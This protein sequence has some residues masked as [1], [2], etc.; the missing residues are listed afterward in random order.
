MV[1]QTFQSLGRGKGFSVVSRESGM[2]DSRLVEALKP[3]LLSLMAALVSHGHAS[4][5]EILS[6]IGVE[7]PPPTAEARRS[8][9]S[10]MRMLESELLLE[11]HTRAFLEAD[12]ADLKR[13]L[14]RSLNRWQTTDRQREAAERQLEEQRAHIDR[15]VA[16]TRQGVES[17]RRLRAELGASPMGGP[18]LAEHTRTMRA[19]VEVVRGMQAS[20]KSA[21]EKQPDAQPAR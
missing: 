9:E 19:I 14:Q 5:E 18:A 13:G 6:A 12:V 3:K 11:K 4:A 16:A 7:A 17:L 15:L 2:N 21:P 10:K 20:K 1:L 8:R